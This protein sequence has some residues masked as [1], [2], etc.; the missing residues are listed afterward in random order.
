MSI[1]PENSAHKFD[2][3]VNRV[4]KCRTSNVEQGMSN[5]EWPLR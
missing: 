3:G 1:D 5:F 2:I 4:L